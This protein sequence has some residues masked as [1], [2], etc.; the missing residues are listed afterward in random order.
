VLNLKVLLITGL[1]AQDTVRRYA[2]ESKTETKLFT[3]QFP[4]AALLT[5]EK[6]LKALQNSTYGK[7]DM[8]L[9]PGLIRG[10]VA[11]ISEQLGIPVFKGPRYAA[12]LPTILDMVNEITFST[13][14]PACELLKEKLQQ[15]ALQELEI[16]EK[17]RDF[18]LK[19]PG[20]MHVKGL[21]FGKD[22]PMRVV[23]EIVDAPLMSKEE[24]MRLAKI[25]V[26]NGADVI[27]VGM[28]AG[29][30]R[31]LEAKEAIEEVKSAVNAPVSI[32]TLDPEEIKA[33]VRAGADIVLSGDTGNL[34]Q[35]APYVKNTTVIILPTNQKKGYFPTELHKRVRV[36]EKNIKR[37]K[38]L[39]IENVVGDLVLE[40]TRV[41]ESFMA[42]WEY[43]NRNPNVPLLAGVAN[44]T[45][46]FDADS[47]GVNAMLARLCSEV[48]VNLLLTTEKTPKTK[49]SI[50]EI[51]IASK[52][53]FLSKRRG[54]APEDLGIN[55]LLLKDKHNIGE[56]YNRELE[57]ATQV[58]VV[59]DK[60]L[61]EKIDPKGIFRITID[62][63][64]DSIVVL[65][66]PTTQTSKPDCIIKGKVA[67][68]I[69]TKIIELGLIS[70]LDHAAY[71]GKEL[72]NAE[73]AVRT[74]KIYIQDK[75]LFTK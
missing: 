69:Y 75:P 65:H 37:A 67:Q 71:L 60:P 61:Q 27:D 38:E 16:V 54:S 74:G 34:E 70:V 10:N 11:V 29:E 45:E 9:V 8:I 57:T 13:V 6:I 63:E 4:V 32:D 18:L 52:M 3:L 14:T 36:L 33:A 48:G 7:P 43:A 55:L 30:S 58:T 73:V 35:I 39:G 12:D 53:M 72:S 41:L 23:A 20:N 44:V 31:P 28:V 25:Y 40:P 64:D 66:Y 46:L 26:H 56:N 17:K 22:F 1:L 24:I 15:K 5:P 2:Q 59:N 47:V 21:A 62:A 19:K 68:N 50:K 42:F 51:A 49:G